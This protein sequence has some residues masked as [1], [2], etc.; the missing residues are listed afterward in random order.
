[1]KTPRKKINPIIITN[2]KI[3]SQNQYNKYKII[4]HKILIIMTHKEKLKKE[5]P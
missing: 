3:K 5:N 4:E 1:M 2:K